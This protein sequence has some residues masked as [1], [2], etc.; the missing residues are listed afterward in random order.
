MPVRFKVLALLTLI[1]FANYFLRNNI[2]VA[3]PAITET[4]HFSHAEAGWIL[5]T[6]AHYTRDG[7]IPNMFPEGRSQGLY[8]TADASLWY[9]HALNRYLGATGDRAAFEWGSATVCFALPAAGR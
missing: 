8:H 7:L 9:F 2:S 1:S 6:F 4:F 5:R 3:L